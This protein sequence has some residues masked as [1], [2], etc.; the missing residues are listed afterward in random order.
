LTTGEAV[1]SE[2]HVGLLGPLEVELSGEHIQ[3]EGMKQRRLFVL[4]ALRAPEAVSADELLDAL[5]GD[6]PPAGPVQALQKQ[7]SRLRR[8][9]GD[10]SLVRHRPAG[11]ALQIEPEAVDL[12]RFEDLLDRGRFALGREDPQR[13]A[14]DLREALA[15]WRGEALADH[16]FDEF[17]QREI[18]R[19][20]D[21]RVQAIEERMAAEL[22]CGHDAD[23]VGELSTL[24][25]EHPLR[26]RLRG[27][28]MLALYRT[29]RQAEAL[30]TMRTGRR[31]LVEELGIEPGPELRRLE[32]MI[33]AHDP[34][35]SA[36]RPDAGLAAPIPAPANETI[37]REGE[38]SQIVEL[39]IRPDV[40]L[41]TLVGPAA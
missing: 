26:E 18:A 6:S 31:L 40:R 37:G 19:L 8:R 41:L 10:G 17:A 11:Y 34:G 21:L 35:L 3:F 38:V 28:L 12:R 22:A 25:A 1:S 30:E 39:L 16:R 14:A 33:L 9:L 7:I 36:E 4:L 13:A 24:V 15:L 27:Q 20:E 2:M 29:G 23:V 32:R 5:W